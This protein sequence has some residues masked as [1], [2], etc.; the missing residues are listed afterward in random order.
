LFA[1]LATATHGWSMNVD[2]LSEGVVDYAPAIKI[3]TDDAFL[4][5]LVCRRHEIPSPSPDRANVRH[6]GGGH[7]RQRHGEHGARRLER[8][9]GVAQLWRQFKRQIVPVATTGVSPTVLDAVR[10]YERIAPVYA[11]DGVTAVPSPTGDPDPPG[12]HITRHAH[13]VAR[14][15]RHQAGVRAQARLRLDLGRARAAVVR[16]HH[17]HVDWLRRRRAALREHH[18]R[19]DRA[20]RAF[21]TFATF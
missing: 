6:V 19:A 13:L 8:H 1:S 12:D 20:G 7:H 4:T 14:L 11:N 9:A 17:Q 3:V 18:A 5:N 10:L 16:R 15:P 21:A 2:V